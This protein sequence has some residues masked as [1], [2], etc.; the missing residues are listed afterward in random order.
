[1]RDSSNPNNPN[2]SFKI[3]IV[4]E[5]KQTQKEARKILRSS[6]VLHGI[7]NFHTDSE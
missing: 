5:W 3:F 7:L 1:V 4:P 6:A 2:I